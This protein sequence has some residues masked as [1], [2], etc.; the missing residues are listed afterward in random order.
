MMPLFSALVDIPDTLSARPRKCVSEF[1]DLMNELVMEH[2]DM[3]VLDFV[4][5]LIARTG[6]KA[7]YEKDQSDEGKNRIE[8][9]DEFLGAVAEY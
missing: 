5:H 3:G 9:I 6:L 7:Q 2:E 8:N 4:T 1:G